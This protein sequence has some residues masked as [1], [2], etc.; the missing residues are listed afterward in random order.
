MTRFQLRSALW[1]CYLVLTVV[2]RCG[3]GPCQCCL[4]VWITVCM[5]VIIISTS[6]SAC[7]KGACPVVSCCQFEAPFGPHW[8]TSCAAAKAQQRRAHS[9]QAPGPVRAYRASAKSSRSTQK[10]ATTRDLAA[11]VGWLANV[12]LQDAWPSRV[13]HCVLVLLLC[14]V[15][16]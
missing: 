2:R 4:H 10:Q 9:I 14:T 15:H 16:N 8:P 3:F 12:P 6:D 11:H 7:H 13:S 5:T 1:R